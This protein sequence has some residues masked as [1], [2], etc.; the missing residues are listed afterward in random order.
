MNPPRVALKLDFDCRFKLEFYGSRIASDG[1]LLAYRWRYDA[2]GL[3]AM[4]SDVLAEA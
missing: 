1:G 2:L 4:A 3:N